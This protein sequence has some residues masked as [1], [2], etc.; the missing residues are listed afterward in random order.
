MKKFVIAVFVAAYAAMLV[1]AVSAMPADADCVTLIKG[2][3]N[4]TVDFDCPDAT[5][6]DGTACNLDE[7]VIVTLPDIGQARQKYCRCG[8]YSPI[9]VCMG[10]GYI[11][12]TNNAWTY[13]CRRN[14]CLKPCVEFPNPPPP[15]GTP[16]CK[17]P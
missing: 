17:C 7:S 4:G 16:V 5:C 13:A 9:N 14:G 6:D 11:S 15:G 2:S 10:F 8:D 12:T 3:P 1:A